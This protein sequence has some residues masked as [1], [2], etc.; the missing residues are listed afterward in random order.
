MAESEAKTA[1][2]VH[3]PNPYD[4]P[5]QEM[6]PMGLLQLALSKG[7]SVEQLEKLMDLQLRWQ[8]NEARQA[9]VKALNAFKADPPEILKNNHVR[10][11]EG[12]KQV[13][14]DHATLDQVCRQVSGGLS[15]HGI[16][17]RWRVTQDTGLVRVTC[18]LTHDLGHF[19]ETTLAAGPD[20][21]GG[22]NNI[23]ALGSTV[24]YL[25]R[26][27]LLA[28]TGLAAKNG[29]DDGRSAEE[30]MKNLQE[31]VSAIEMCHNLEILQTTFKTA[32]GEAIKAE[33]TSAVK[34]LVMAKDKRKAELLKDEPAQ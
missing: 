9:F 30:K 26:Y 10:Y 22:K 12:D 18:I 14:Y 20:A 8:A 21:S 15:K 2:I 32:V 24:T 13:D 4:E 25:E 33:S 16:S 28:A 7:T 17:H 27:T 6:T 31:H 19:E 23:Q 11:G 3:A 34:A 5:Q 1:E 29:D